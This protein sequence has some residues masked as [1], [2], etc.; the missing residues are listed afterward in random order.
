MPTWWNVFTIPEAA[1][2]SSP[3]SPAMPAEVIGAK[4]RPCP[5]P[6]G[7]I[8]SATAP[9]TNRARK[10][11]QPGHP[12]Q[13]QR[14]ARGERH[15]LPEPGREAGDGHRDG[16]V[17]DRHRENAIPASNAVKSSTPC[18]YWVPK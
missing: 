5:A 11:A 2:A 16:E 18:R 8:G 10:P 9:R 6:T 17:H 7:T 3:A 15:G 13:G 1:P 12:D 4:A 14:D